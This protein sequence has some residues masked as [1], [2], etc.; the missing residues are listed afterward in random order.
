M[1]RLVPVLAVV[2][3]AAAPRAARAHQASLTHSEV[4]VDDAE[5][6][7]RIRIARGDLAEAIGRDPS[8]VPSLDELRAAAPRV[9]DYVSARIDVSDGARPCPAEPGAVDGDGDDHVAITWIARCPAAVEVLTIDYDLFFELDPTHEALVRVVA[10]GREAAAI[11]DDDRSRFVWPLAE[12]PPSGIGAFVGSGVDHILLGFDHVAFVLA[13]LLA[14]PLAA[15]PGGWRRRRLGEALRATAVIVTSFTVAHSV[16]LVAAALGW[17]SVPA[18][19]VEA[20][21]ALSIV[22][23]AVENVVRPAARWRF[24]LTAGFGLLHGLGFARMLEVLLP[25]DDAVVP[26]L[27][28]N[29]GVELG[30]LAIVAVA[31]PPAWL[32]AGALGPDRYRRLALPAL[33]AILAGLGL[34]WLAERVLEVTILGL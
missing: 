7:W 6:R 34:V 18:R 9:I 3:V 12:P 1:R 31:L 5:V 25:P 2:A 20:A 4:V 23:T 29:L 28:F 27:A 15:G 30:Q 33:S 11:L 22:Y 26:L 17:V 19:L 21:I 32:L 14:L 8:E 10:G 13:I 16:T 24:A